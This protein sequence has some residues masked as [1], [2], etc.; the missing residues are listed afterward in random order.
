MNTEELKQ[1]I[2]ERVRVPA[3]LLTG[4]TDEE[5]LAQAK[6]FIA[7]KKDLEGKKVPSTPRE[8]FAKWMHEQEGTPQDNTE[9]I[10]LAN[11][12][13]ELKA[14]IYP[15]IPD[16]GS[17]DRAEN[18]NRTNAEKFSEFIHAKTDFDPRKSGRDWAH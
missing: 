13:D 15:N 7:Y 2:V 3:A 18:D 6:A 9:S 14:G 17:I 4:E 16:G 10:A 5:L 11:I 1:K 12:E 8:A